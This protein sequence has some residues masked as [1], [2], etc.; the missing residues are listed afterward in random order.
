[1]PSHTTTHRVV[2]VVTS[3]GPVVV[4]LVDPPALADPAR[5]TRACRDLSARLGFL[6]VVQRCASGN[7]MLFGGDPFLWRYAAD[8]VVEALPVVEVG[9]SRPAMEAVAA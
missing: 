1:M 5:A 6:P 2:F 4:E 8:P 7:A 3:N 9:P